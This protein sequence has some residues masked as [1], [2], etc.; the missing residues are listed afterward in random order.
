[1][2]D[3][4]VTR[5]DRGRVVIPSDHAFAFDQSEGVAIGPTPQGSSIYVFPLSRWIDLIRRLRRAVAHGDPE[6]PAYLEFYTSLYRRERIQGKSR[7]IDIPPHLSAMVGLSQRVV[8]RGRDDRLEIVNE[9][10]WNERVVKLRASVK[11][12]ADSSKWR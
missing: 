9:A 8:I 4:R 2:G 1:M 10:E 11:P 5:D 3:V 6:A 12:T 7:R